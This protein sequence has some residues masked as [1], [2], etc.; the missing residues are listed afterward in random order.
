MGLW[1]G[2]IL[3]NLVVLVYIIVYG[4]E[5][6]EKDFRNGDVVMYSILNFFGLISGCFLGDA[7][8][9]IW[10]TFKSERGLQ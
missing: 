4:K 6:M 10:V 3:N 5:C 1:F 8:R 9:R 2:I 7:L